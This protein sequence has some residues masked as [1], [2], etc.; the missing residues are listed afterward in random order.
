MSRGASARPDPDADLGE[1][2]GPIVLIGP[3]AAG[4][5]HLARYMSRRYGYGFTDSDQVIVSRHG[6]IPEL[7]EAQGEAR[8]RE[9]EAQTI[10]Q[11][12]ADPELRDSIISLGGGAPMTPSVRE[13]LQRH[14]VVYLETD[15]ATV[16]ARLRRGRSRPMLKG[17]PIKRWKDLMKER[18]PVYE[19]LADIRLD[20]TRGR[21]ITRI[22]GE[23]HEEIQAL[24]AL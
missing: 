19:A 20:S 17:D 23:L 16:R 22:A 12:L 2:D 3:M 15:V 8:F 10:A 9:I 24:R 21:P 18:R 13:L 7:F 6:P 4:K 11:L 1:G 5:S 14:M